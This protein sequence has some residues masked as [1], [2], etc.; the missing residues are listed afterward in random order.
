MAFYLKVTPVPG[1]LGPWGFWGHRTC[2]QTPR[3]VPGKPG[4]SVTLFLPHVFLSQGLNGQGKKERFQ[5]R[6]L[7][8]TRQELWP[9]GTACPR[10]SLRKSLE[11]PPSSSVPTGQSPGSQRAQ[12]PADKGDMP[13]PGTEKGGRERS[14]NPA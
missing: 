1:L 8:V 7:G 4:W 2:V 12:V 9:R 5:K 11:Y 6:G 13:S 10:E 14:I 3:T